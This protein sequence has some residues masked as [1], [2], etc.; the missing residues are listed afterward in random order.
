VSHFGA[1]L[2]SHIF[3]NDGFPEVFPSFW[4]MYICA[5]HCLLHHRN[6]PILIHSGPQNAPNRGQKR[7]KK[8]VPKS[9]RFGYPFASLSAPFWDPQICKKCPGRLHGCPWAHPMPPLAALER[10]LGGPSPCLGPHDGCRTTTLG[11]FGVRG[12]I[13]GPFW[14]AWSLILALRWL[15]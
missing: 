13:L 1:N 7:T 3:R 6:C 15:I 14:G 12:L 10:S 4:L 2:V 8:Q 5:K 11:H 9:T